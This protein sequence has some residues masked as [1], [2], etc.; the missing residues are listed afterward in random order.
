MKLSGVPVSKES[1]RA[2]PDLP[3]FKFAEAQLN[4]GMITMVDPADIPPGA[5]QLAKNAVI[6]FD[7]TSRRPGSI[8]LTPVKP[9]GSPVM[10]MA[11]IKQKDGTAYTL[12]FTPTAI[13][14]RGS[15]SWTSMTGTLA[16]TSK[17]RIQT[18]VIQNEL[19]FTNNGANKIQK[20]DF[21]LAS[22]GDLGNSLE[23][24][25]ITGFY[26]RALGAAWRDTNEVLV[27]WSAD[28]DVDEWDPAV[29]E[30]AGS[31]PILESPADL[32]DFITG[33][34]SWTNMGVLLR[35]RSLWT[36]QKQA[37][38]QNPFF[39]STAVPGIGCDSP[40]SAQI[41]GT[42]IGWLDRRTG[43][44]YSWQPGS[45]PEP[46]GR[47]IEK[48]ILSNVDDP[49]TIFSSYD[50]LEQEYSVCIPQ[51]G[52]K[53]VNVWTFNL[54]NQTWARN[55]YYALT[56]MDDVDLATAG[57]TIDQLGDVAIDDLIG[58]IDDL[59]PT[60]KII[61]TRIYGRDDGSV[62]QI[63]VNTDVDAP[64]TDFPDGQAYEMQ[65][66]SKVF[67]IPEDDIY[68][69]EIRIEY[70]SQRGGTF[71]LEHSKNG[72]YT[73]ESWRLSKEVTPK[74]LGEP[75]LLIFRRFI[76]CREFAWRLTTKAGLFDVLSFEVHCYPS[77]KS[78]K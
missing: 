55:E 7:R 4:K 3:S 48:S 60:S 28:G 14:N 23:Y 49:Q 13:H 30:T 67:S 2:P 76:K 72:G 6:R 21:G 68:I 71:K 11:A 15:S 37:I 10:R 61:S 47:P 65:L 66:V 5:L 12:R 26:N 54:R 43:T 45:L 58:T 44:V 51:T 33:L 56:C 70:L 31:S 38:P 52:S 59:S 63:E 24:R 29:N 78:V 50:T 35:E 18:A 17:D 27:G 9:D 25:Y 42:R 73:T 77:G 19:I 75:R 46:I 32:N 39:F 1:F 41:I 74:I 20:V 57:L 64:H 62:G 8:L 34:F 36:I 40:Y 69:A 22:F 53:Y 16:G